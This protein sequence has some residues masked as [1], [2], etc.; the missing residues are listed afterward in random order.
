MSK[1][2]LIYLLTR[3]S[4]ELITRMNTAS[5]LSAPA[6]MKAMSP[7]NG[8]NKMPMH[9][10]TMYFQKHWTRRT[11]CSACQEQP[12]HQY[13]VTFYFTYFFI[14]NSVHMD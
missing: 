2:R 6:N 8:Q 14:F 7:S 13:A 11:G 12:K 10:K 1:Q 5:N 3:Q 4:V 9:E